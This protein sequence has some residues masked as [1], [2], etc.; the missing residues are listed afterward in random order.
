M[1]DKENGLTVKAILPVHVF[2][3]PAE[4][5]AIQE[6]AAEY[7]LRIIEDAC[8]AIG[9]EYR[10]RRVGTFGDAAVFAFYPNKQMTTGEGGMI[11]T[12]DD[13]IAARCRSLRNQGRDADGRWLRHTT[14]GYNYRLSDVQCALGCA[15]LS[16]I[17]KLLEARAQVASKYIEYLQDRDLVNLPCDIPGRSR[18]WFI[19]YVRLAGDG[20]MPELRDTVRSH[21]AN[22][23]IATQAYFPA[24]HRQPYF[25]GLFPGESFDL[26][27]TERASNTCLALPFFPGLSA[28]EIRHVVE[29]L[30][31]ACLTQ[32]VGASIPT[33]GTDAV[34]GRN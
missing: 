6:V 33:K 9:A 20:S 23:G 8:E 28:K 7:G 32:A 22:E 14:L 34:L 5:D 11:V 1:I 21:L 13:E 25:A 15:Q 31:A 24:I 27:E 10:G 26:P 30:E 16:R 3:L 19:F 18:S 2:G 4:M 12:D 17:D 29:T